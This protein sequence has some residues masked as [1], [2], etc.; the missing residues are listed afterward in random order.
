MRTFLRVSLL[1]NALLDLAC[2]LLLLPHGSEN[3][4]RDAALSPEPAAEQAAVDRYSPIGVFAV[5][6]PFVPCELPGSYPAGL[7]DANTMLAE[8]VQ[9]TGI[10]KYITAYEVGWL[11][12]R[13]EGKPLDLRLGEGVFPRPS[14]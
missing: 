9:F 3:Q 8:L 14:P 7:L 13:F 12:W 2:I 10:P 1:G 11:N 6:T 5:E 4:P